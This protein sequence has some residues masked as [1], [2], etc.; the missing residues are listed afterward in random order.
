[1]RTK[2]HGADEAAAEI[3]FWPRP[4]YCRTRGISLAQERRERAAG[5]GPPFIIADR[6]GRI[7]Y[8]VA[9]A[10]AFIRNLPR[11][12]SRAEVYAAHPE[13]AERDAKQSE[14]MEQT[15]KQRWT[16]ETRARHEPRRRAGKTA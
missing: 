5:V 10:K 11:F 3:G 4:E 16:A 7:L 15:R 2:D 14:N 1:L 9:E 13:L 8:P 6:N 12:A